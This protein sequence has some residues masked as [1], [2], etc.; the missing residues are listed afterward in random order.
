MFAPYL[1]RGRLYQ[2]MKRC[3]EAM[4]DFETALALNPNMG[5]IFYSRSYCHTLNGNKAAALQDVETAIQ[6]GFRQIDPAYYN[7]L[8]G[9]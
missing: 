4:A 5:E 6:L 9:R 8:K 3:T 7:M 2:R 1:N